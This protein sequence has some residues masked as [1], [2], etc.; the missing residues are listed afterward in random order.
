ML[1]EV[2]LVHFDQKHFEEVWPLRHYTYYAFKGRVIKILEEPELTKASSGEL[3]E[4]KQGPEETLD[5]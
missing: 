3:F 2:L 4:T 1:G 5:D